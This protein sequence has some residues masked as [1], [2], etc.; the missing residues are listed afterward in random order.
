VKFLLDENLSP[1]HAETV[2]SWGYDALSVVESGLRGADDSIVRQ[3]AIAG[4]RILI[5]LDGDFGNVLR[6]PPSATPGVIRLRL[7]P[8]TEEA[9]NAALRFAILRLTGMHLTGK[10]VVVDERKIRIRG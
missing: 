9:I 2:R 7:H 3:A 8:P 5:T 6:F 1:R 10:L 4:G